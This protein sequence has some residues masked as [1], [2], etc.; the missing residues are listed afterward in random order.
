M[1]ASTTRRATIS[2]VQPRG[3]VHSLVL[4]DPALYLQEQLRR[5]GVRVQV[6]KNRLTAGEVNFVFGAHLGFDRRWCEQ[7]DCVFVN[8]EQ[9]GP[10]GAALSNR[11]LQLLREN[12]VVDY[13]P[14]HREHLGPAHAAAPLLS[15]GYAPYLAPADPV[16]IEERPLDLLFFGSFNE[17]RKTVLERLQRAGANVFT[18]PF[19]VYG[20]DRDDLVRQAKAVV[21]V[22]HYGSGR[23]E[24][25][26]ASVVLSCG[27]PLVS[28][29][30]PP[31]DDVGVYTSTVH[32]FDP[33]APEAF[34]EFFRSPEFAAR[35]HAMLEEFARTPA[36]AA[37]VYDELASW[38]K[39]SPVPTMP[40]P[41]LREAAARDGSPVRVVLDAPEGY[42]PGWVNVSTR[43]ERR[44]DWLLPAFSDRGE[45]TV[46]TERWGPV[47]VVGGEA[48]VVELG[49]VDPHP[50]R[51]DAVLRW[52]LHLLA[53]NGAVSLVWPG[54]APVE[55]LESALQELWLHEDPRHLLAL[56]HASAVP[57]TPGTP[58]GSPP[59]ARVVLRKTPCSPT[60]RSL[61]MAAGQ[62]FG[63]YAE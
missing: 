32:W 59:A 39:V 14:A 18:A 45:L 48:D 38:A 19:G 40:V 36:P 41:S 1:T 60:Q 11:Y 44:P 29:V 35:S 23:F 57:A 46:A 4:L 17:R 31:G 43:P 22:G 25:V 26:R 6:V 42:R 24:Q 27:T 47:G 20:A 50:V 33:E 15:F 16:P 34:L 55:V 53:E 58:A 28:E 30:R 56:M 7:F 62:T 12:R 61:G 2:I 54:G 37:G 9:L 5:R 10:S 13:D 49:E 52:A 8:L 21:N 63:R 3:Y 51:L